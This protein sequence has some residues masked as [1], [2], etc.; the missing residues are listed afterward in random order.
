LEHRKELKHYNSRACEDI[1]NPGIPDRPTSADKSLRAYNQ[2][3]HSLDSLR[4][5]A[6]SNHDSLL[7]LLFQISVK[8]F[9]FSRRG[10]TFL[11]IK[12]TI[13]EFRKCN[14]DKLLRA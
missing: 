2:V 3:G 14:K 1:F 4:H 7:F 13:G 5:R 11:N 9:V 12:M 8:T 6:G 10:T